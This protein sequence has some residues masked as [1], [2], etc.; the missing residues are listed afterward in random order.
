MVT[1]KV[2]DWSQINCIIS[3]CSILITEVERIFHRICITTRSVLRKMFI[4][5]A[6]YESLF[7][8][9]TFLST[10]YT[11]VNVHLITY[12]GLWTKRFRYI[13]KYKQFN[14]LFH[15]IN[16]GMGCRKN[17]SWSLL[18]VITQCKQLLICFIRCDHRVCAA[19]DWIYMYV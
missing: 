3:T 7:F 19:Y 13:G 4:A 5:K 18:V 11:K 16:E 6:C 2:T 9:V 1:N 12:N 10:I 15:V 8:R 17:L 14:V